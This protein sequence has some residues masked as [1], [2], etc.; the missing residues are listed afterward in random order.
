MK[1][2]T[3]F[4]LLLAVL[5]AVLPA[6]AQ[7][8]DPVPVEES[9]LSSKRLSIA[10][11]ADYAWVNRGPLTLDEVQGFRGWDAVVSAGYNLT[12][13]VDVVG[14]VGYALHDGAFRSTLGFRILIFDGGK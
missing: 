3:T 8:Q 14:K 11:G 4:L 12:P 1:A 5:L 7:A 13:S 10:I 2:I 9:L 6:P